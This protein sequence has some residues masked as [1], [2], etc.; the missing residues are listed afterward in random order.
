[1]GERRGRADAA[2]RVAA[3]K[4]WMDI[5]IVVADDG[6]VRIADTPAE[7]EGAFE[8]YD[9]TIAMEERG[10][11]LSNG[12]TWEQRWRNTFRNIR[13][14]AENPDV[15]ISYIVTRRRQRGLPELAD[16]PEPGESAR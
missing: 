11:V 4:R 16:A 14:S 8:A 9:R 7:R 1:M 6:R 2:R 12:W 13:S 3:A 15:L 5:D 10:H